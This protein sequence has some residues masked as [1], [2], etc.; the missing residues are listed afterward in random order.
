MNTQTTHRAQVNQALWLS[1]LLAA[2]ALVLSLIFW[3]KVPDPMPI[4]WNEHGVPDGFGS[5]TCGLLLMPILTLAL[6]AL[7]AGMT[8][9]DPRRR[10]VSRSSNAL[11]VIIGGLAA[12]MFALHGVIIKASIHPTMTLDAGLLVLLVG[13]FFIILGNAMPKFGSNHFVGIRT[14]WTLQDEKVWIKTHQLAGKLFVA[15]GLLSMVLGFFIPV[16]VM[17]PAFLGLTLFI[18]LAPIAYSWWIFDKD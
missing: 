7:I 9:I 1:A 4:H 2:F 6:P 5:K 15:G 17:F 16:H 3:D 18:S 10:H 12:F 14:P 8:R 11:A 13:A